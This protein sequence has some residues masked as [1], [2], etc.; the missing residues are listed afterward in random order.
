MGEPNHTFRILLVDDEQNILKSLSRLLKSRSEHRVETAGSGKEALSKMESRTADIIVSDERMPDM[1]GSELLTRIRETYPDTVRIIITGYADTQ[2]ILHAVNEGNIYRFLKKPWDNDEFLEVIQSAA[3]HLR[4]S[5][6]NTRLQ[7]ELG[8]RNRELEKL[9]GELEARVEKRTAELRKS[10]ARLKQAYD[11][12]NRQNASV[13]E[14]I[15]SILHFSRP[16]LASRASRAAGLARL[17]QGY[18]GLE[19]S[20]YNAMKN[21]AM[22]HTAGGLKEES[23]AAMSWRELARSSASMLHGFHRLNSFG[24]LLKKAA[25]PAADPEARSSDEAAPAILRM[26]LDFDEQVR[27]LEQDPEAGIDGQS[28]MERA[29]MQ[30]SGKEIPL[31]DSADG[32]G[33]R[34]ELT[35]AEHWFLEKL[36]KKFD[37]KERK[38]KTL[39]ADQLIPGQRLA[40]SVHLQTGSMVL[41]EGTDLN[42]EHIENLK[43]ISRLLKEEI[44]VFS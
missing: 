32:E 35:A 9:N 25:H 21:S 2:A 37:W 23:D 24:E 11:V 29:F 5:R 36:R 30:V 28:I 27:S 16:Y 44:S 8:V 41:P 20:E 13:L 3:H 38:V 10:Y 42:E 39:S 12:V 18:P 31:S 4:I 40:R 14:L 1:R 6:E 22:L 7:K 34:G 26:I 15:H 17:F 43:R 33:K 19:E